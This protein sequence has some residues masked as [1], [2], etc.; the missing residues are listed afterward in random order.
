MSTYRQFAERILFSSSLEEKLAAPTQ[1]LVDDAAGSG[2]VS[3]LTPERPRELR[4]AAIGEHGPKPREDRLSEDRERGLLLHFFCN[5]EL[6]ATELMAL[7][8][9]KFPDA[10][11]AF[12]KGLLHTL[13]E[14]QQHTQWYL[15]RMAEC[16]VSFGEY[17]VNGFFWRSIA[18]MATPM[19]YVARLSLTFEQ[20][21][22]DYAQHYAKRFQEAGDDVTGALLQQIYKDEIAHVGYGLKWFRRWKGQHQ[23]DWQAFQELLAF[24]LSPARAK[25]TMHFNAAGR[26]KVG[27]DEE[28]IAALELYSQSRGRTPWV[29]VFNPGAEAAAAARNAN[30]MDP[31]TRQLTQDL[32]TL[33]FFLAN[34]EDTVLLQRE[35]RGDFL[36]DLKS[37]GVELPAQEILVQGKLAVKSELRNRKLGRLRPWGWSPDAHE[38]LQDLM[39]NLPASDQASPWSEGTRQLYTKAHAAQCLAQLPWQ[40]AFGL[41]EII[42]SAERTIEELWAA[43]HT[44][45][46]KANFGIAGRSMARFGPGDSLAALEPLRQLPGGYIVEPWLERVADFS[47]QYEC[48]PNQPPRLKGLVRLHCEPSGR[49]TACVASGTFTRLLPS[50]VARFLNEQGSQWLKQLYGTEIPNVLAPSIAGSGF[51]GF[52]GIDAFFY[53]DADGSVRLKPIVEINPRCTMGRTTWELLR[54]AAPGHTVL[55]RIFSKSAMKKAGYPNFP[56]GLAALQ[57]RHPRHFNDAGQLD[58]GVFTLNDPAT[59]TGFLAVALASKR[60]IGPDALTLT[61]DAL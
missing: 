40:A 49:F 48:E 52:L 50:E 20:A 13:Q 61:R 21:N 44:A 57:A 11:A 28:F 26:R 32:D 38:L 12:R 60:A 41:Q 14:E 33:P 54:V 34:A 16:G 25:G 17:P 55:M 51:R 53:R 59:A 27:L 29:Y 31:A 22:L 8:L 58:G 4:F 46:V 47:A 7:A 35:P 43:G 23:S 30:A 24:P 37:L 19:D 15:K 39:P 36:R 2:I 5:H 1:P 18:D 45:V 42:G 10:P 3:P 6:L 56:A 9:L